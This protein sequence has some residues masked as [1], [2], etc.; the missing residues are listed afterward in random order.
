MSMHRK[1]V[2]DRH[3]GARSAVAIKM[4]VRVVSPSVRNEGMAVFRPGGNDAE[5]F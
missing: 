4:G 2:L 5:L 3:Y 1:K